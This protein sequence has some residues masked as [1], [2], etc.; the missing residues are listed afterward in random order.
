MAHGPSPTITGAQKGAAVQQLTEMQKQQMGLITTVSRHSV[1]PKLAD[2]LYGPARRSAENEVAHTLPY[3]IRAHQISMTK[4]HIGES[5]LAR[6]Y[7]ERNL[8]TNLVQEGKLS[9][10]DEML[11]VSVK[12]ESGGFV[13]EVHCKLVEE[14]LGP[15]RSKEISRIAETESG[16]RQLPGSSKAESA[17]ALYLDMAWADIFKGEG[18]LRI[19]DATMGRLYE[20][21]KH[22]IS[23]PEPIAIAVATSIAIRLTEEQALAK[24]E[25]ASASSA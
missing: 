25:G 4:E 19:D 17:A 3:Y 24:M 11:L 5:R 22:P 16:N 21:S 18:S 9:Q 1:D 10:V 8:N 12:L 13:K 14:L 23:E 6:G 20:V 15:T 2:A 7:D